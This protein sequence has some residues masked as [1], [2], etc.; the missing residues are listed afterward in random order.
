MID[1]F[2]VRY[3]LTQLES[4]YHL[5]SKKN[6]A[7]MIVLIIVIKPIAQYISLRIAL[8]GKFLSSRSKSIV[9]RFCVRYELTLK[10]AKEI[11]YVYLYFSISV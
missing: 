1:M 2:C 4:L 6:W 10:S 9:S 8:E 5:C 3:Q 11:P 7:Y